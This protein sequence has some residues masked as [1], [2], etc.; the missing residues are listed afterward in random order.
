M[1]RTLLVAAVLAVAIAP[2]FAGEGRGIIVTGGVGAAIPTSQFNDRLDPQVSVA[3]SISGPITGVF[4]W[5][6]EYSYDRFQ[7]GSELNCTSC[8]DQYINHFAAG[9]QVTGKTQG[10]KVLPYGFFTAGGYNKRSYVSGVDNQT[11]FGLGFGGG[12]NYLVGQNWGIGGEV[13]ANTFRLKDEERAAGQDRWLWY[14]APRGQV[15]FRF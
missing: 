8:R 6:G 5:R 12:V 14:A 13:E 2:A 7:T 15:F 10:G 4:G 11:D 3:G 9:V 1:E